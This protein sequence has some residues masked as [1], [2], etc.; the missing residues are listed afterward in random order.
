VVH[1]PVSKWRGADLATLALMDEKMPIGTRS[2]VAGLQL[3]LKLQE[4]IGQ[5]MLDVGGAGASAAIPPFAK[6]G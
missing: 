2:V 4:P 1:H 3:V 5:P 6:G